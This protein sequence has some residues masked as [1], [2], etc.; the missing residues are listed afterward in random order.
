MKLCFSKQYMSH[1]RSVQK[2][3]A[4]EGYETFIECVSE[5]CWDTDKEQHGIHNRRNK[6]SH[7]A[8][9]SRFLTTAA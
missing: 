3:V 2:N 6:L 4:N 1:R 7:K 9:L 5:I 8:C